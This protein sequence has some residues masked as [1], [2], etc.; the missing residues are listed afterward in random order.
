MFTGIIEEIGKI[1][2]VTKIGNSLRLRIGVKKLADG[3]KL[4]DSLS[5]NGACLTVVNLGRDFFEVDAVEETVRKT[6]LGLLTNGSFV[7]LER[8]RKFDDRIDG[9]IV[10]GHID[11]TGK[12]ERIITAQVSKLF[13]ISFPPQFN[14]FVVSKGSIAV[15]GISL[16]IVDVESNIFSVSIVPFTIENTTLKFRKVGDIVNLEFDIIGKYVTN[17]LRNQA[18]SSPPSILDQFY[19]QPY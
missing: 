11:T 12:I 14:I 9:H 6:N 8:A 16:T 4:G 10:Q 5:V 1:Q 19:E 18:K 17:Y 2:T 7:N 3:M 15:D 13:Y